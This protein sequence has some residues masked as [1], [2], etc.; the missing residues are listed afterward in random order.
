MVKLRKRAS[1]VLSLAQYL[2]SLS[3][4][5][6]GSNNHNIIISRQEGGGED[7]SEEDRV[8]RRKQRRW[9]IAKVVLRTFCVSL[10]AVDAAALIALQTSWN[11]EAYTEGIG[12]PVVSLFSI[13]CQ[14]GNS[15]AVALRCM[16]VY[17]HTY[18][19]TSCAS[20]DPFSAR[21]FKC[22]YRLLCC[23]VF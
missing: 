10:V 18:I 5:D 7:L 4:M 9:D 6:D 21:K 14:I 20:S 11:A 2:Q 1:S 3:V 17:I 16:C 23:V 8:R 12:Y 19:H 22:C 15:N 13:F